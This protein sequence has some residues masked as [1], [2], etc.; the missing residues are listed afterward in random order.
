MF[1]VFDLDLDFLKIEYDDVQIIPKYLNVKPSPIFYK[2][3]T[4]ISLKCVCSRKQDDSLSETRCAS[5]DD[6]H[7]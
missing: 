5:G 3:N 4:R 2:D 6:K 1:Y 7:L